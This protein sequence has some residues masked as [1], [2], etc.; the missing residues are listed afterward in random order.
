MGL[1][2]AGWGPPSPPWVSG[3]PVAEGVKPC[4]E[5]SAGPL[6]QAIQDAEA[7]VD[8]LRQEAQKAEETLAMARLE[9]REQ[10]EEGGRG[11]GL[12]GG[13]ERSGPGRDIGRWAF[14]LAPPLC[15]HRGGRGARD[16]VPGH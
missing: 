6:L 9:L 14:W 13:R 3:P 1:L 12:Q 15:L 4:S 2:R 10:T 16:E 11:W 5:R 8:R 7:Q